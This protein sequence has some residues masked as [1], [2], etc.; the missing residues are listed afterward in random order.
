MYKKNILSFIFLCSIIFYDYAC[1]CC[2]G[3]DVDEVINQLWNE[4]ICKMESL[5]NKLKGKPEKFNF[6]IVG[7]CLEELNVAFERTIK[8]AEPQRPRPFWQIFFMKL[9]NCLKLLAG[10]NV[11]SSEQKQQSVVLINRISQYRKKIEH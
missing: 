9:E 5:E 7:S 4:L 1:E 10:L 11:S 2:S 8:L 3:Q 6:E